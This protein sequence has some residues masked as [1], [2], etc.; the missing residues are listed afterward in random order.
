MKNVNIPEGYPQLMPYLIVKNAAN[1][2]GF[3]RSVFG[4]TEKFKRSTL[5]TAKGIR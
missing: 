4:A 5:V 1:F 2:I 3:T